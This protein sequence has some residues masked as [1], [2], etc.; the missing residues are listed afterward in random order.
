[1]KFNEQKYRQDLKK[2]L[3]LL[4]IPDEDL[5][6]CPIVLNSPTGLN[7]HLSITAKDYI[8]NEVGIAREAYEELNINIESN[9]ELDNIDVPQNTTTL[10]S[11]KTSFDPKKIQYFDVNVPK[12]D[13]IIPFTVAIY[14]ITEDFVSWQDSQTQIHQVK[15]HFTF[16]GE[17]KPEDL[18][19][20]ETIISYYQFVNMVSNLIHHTDRNDVAQKIAEK[21]AME[22]EG[23]DIE[24]ED[25]KKQFGF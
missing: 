24:I 13:A 14:V 19:G 8:D 23:D 2:M 16:I 12:D 25:L 1:M 4:D 6:K 3:G 10:L 5:D 22:F 15:N 17:R 18:T 7:S 21:I 9:V 11:E 20:L